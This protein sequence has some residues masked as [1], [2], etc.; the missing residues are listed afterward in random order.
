MTTPAS[1]EDRLAGA[2][3]VRVV[4]QGGRPN[5]TRVLGVSE[6]AGLLACLAVVED[7]EFQG[8]CL[9]DGEPHLEF[10]RHGELLETVGVHHGSA[11]RWRGAD[12]DQTLVDGARLASWLATH[13]APGLQEEMAAQDRRAEEARRDLEAW[14]AE[15]P[16]KVRSW[17]SVHGEEVRRSGGVPEDAWVTLKDCLNASEVEDVGQVR[18]LFRWFAAGVGRWTGYPSYEDTPARLLGE[19]GERALVDAVLTDVS[20]D[21]VL[22][23]AARWFA[24]SGRRGRGRPPSALRNVLLEHVL[25]TPG[26]ADR[27]ARARRAFGSE[28]GAGKTPA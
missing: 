17:W 1:L 6:V 14:E 13:G 20:D 24:G 27:E 5:R 23:G 7:P 4:G 18:L 3:E 21:R 28:A 2:D 12:H 10:Y 16:A 11:I 26:D 9:C 22:E 8:W 19:R 25:G 15:L